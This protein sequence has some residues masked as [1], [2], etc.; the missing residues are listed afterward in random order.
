MIPEINIWAV[1]L[2]TLSSMVVGSVWYTP[3]V[4][5][6]YWM[7][8]AKVTPSGDAK[9]AVKP[10][11]I[12]LVVSFVS[13]LVLAGSAAISQHFYGGN[14]L[15]NTLIT[16]VI[17]W[18]GF[19]ASRFITHDAFDGRPAALTVLNCA[20]ELVTLVV[21]GLIIGLFGISAA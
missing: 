10:I 7:K 1:V 19:T 12:T 4:F 20:H 13:A 21:M 3:K 15:A 11:L 8:L 5:G 9:D 2:A 6:N 18:A 16:A 17:L 14:F